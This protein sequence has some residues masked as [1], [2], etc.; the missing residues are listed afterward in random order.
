MAATWKPVDEHG[1]LSAEDRKELPDSAY[2]FPGKRKDPL[3][4]A[5]A[6]R[7]AL[8]RADQPKGVTDDRRDQEFECIKAAAKHCKNDSAGSDWRHLGKKPR[9]TSP[10]K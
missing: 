2:A 10:P 8:A 4:D 3:A 1:A 5:D 7:A 9:A 6:G